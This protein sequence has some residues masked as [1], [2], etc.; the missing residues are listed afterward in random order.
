[1]SRHRAPVPGAAAV[2]RKPAVRTAYVRFHALSAA[3][4]SAADIAERS[5]IHR[6]HVLMMFSHVARGDRRIGRR[7]SRAARGRAGAALVLLALPLGANA[8]VATGLDLRHIRQHCGAVCAVD[9]GSARVMS[10][11]WSARASRRGAATSSRASATACARRDTRRSRPGG[12]KSSTVA[13]PSISSSGSASS[14]RGASVEGRAAGR[15]SSDRPSAK[16]RCALG[17]RCR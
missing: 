5:M 1:M 11:A 6:C 4:P 12:A 3:S 7:T 14:S 9:I 15:A 17:R 10:G 13:G 16:A 2:R 8:P